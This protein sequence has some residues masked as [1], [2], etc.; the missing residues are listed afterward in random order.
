MFFKNF[1]NVNVNSNTVKVNGRT[2]KLPSNCNCSSMSIIGNDVYINGVKYDGS[3]ETEE[4]M[5]KDMKKIDFDETIIAISAD[6]ANVNVEIV[7]DSQ[8]S[9]SYDANEH[10]V[11]VCGG[12][13]DIKSKSN[14]IN[15]DI[16]IHLSKKHLSSTLTL[17]IEDGGNIKFDAAEEELN[18]SLSLVTENGNIKA[19][20]NTTEDV[21][22][23]CENGN[24]KPYLNCC[25]VDIKASNG[26]IKGEIR[27]KEDG[28]VKTT[29][30]NIKLCTMSK[31]TH[32]VKNGNVKIKNNAIDTSTIDVKVSNGNLKV[33]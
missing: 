20:S 33:Y 31:I 5:K 13:I 10:E 11:N 3:E 24:I 23:H 30:G 9:I 28:T 21:T 8:S 7:K 29:N 18:T 17:N 4:S 1:N 27:T 19:N 14:Y 16:N 12:F 2:I 25:G 15:T 22:L 6:A 26:N 32:K